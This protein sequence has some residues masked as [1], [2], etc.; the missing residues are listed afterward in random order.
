MTHHVGVTQEELIE[1]LN[2][3][4]TEGGC[5]GDQWALKANQVY[6]ELE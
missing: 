3:A 5:T 2:I 6:K 4:I 1:F